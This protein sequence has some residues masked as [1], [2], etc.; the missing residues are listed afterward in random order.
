[1][2]GAQNEDDL[3]ALTSAVF[4]I[5]SLAHGHLEEA[6]KLFPVLPRQSISVLFPSVRC[7]IFLDALLKADFNPYHPSLLENPSNFWYQIRLLRYFY[8]KTF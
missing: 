8:F 7:K 1:M 2:R 6:K 3:K 5:A 4:E